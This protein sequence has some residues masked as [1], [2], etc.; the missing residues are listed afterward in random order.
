MTSSRLK[1]LLTSSKNDKKR[2]GRTISVPAG[3]GFENMRELPEIKP[4]VK[5][6]G[7]RSDP[8]HENKRLCFF[9]GKTVAP[10]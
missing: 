3:L 5:Q 6:N 1:L 2:P 9:V 8:G 4:K 10:A 7:A